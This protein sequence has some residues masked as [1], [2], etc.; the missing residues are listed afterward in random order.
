MS[1]MLISAS[2]I[3]LAATCARWVAVLALLVS[4]PVT[5]CRGETATQGQSN[6]Y[7]RIVQLISNEDWKAA[8]DAAVSYLAKVG[9]SGDEGLQARLRYIIIYTTAGA[10]STGAFEFDVLDQRVK[11]F[12]SKS[13]TLPYRPVV[14]GACEGGMNAICI[15]DPHATSFMVV[16]A[17]KTSTTI[18][19][20]EYVTLQ[21]AVDFAARG[22][23]WASITGTLRKIEPNPNK[24]R[25]I[26]MRIYIDDATVAFSKHS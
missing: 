4:V 21:Q 3:Q 20:F 11:G 22:A 24:S 5:L 18:H 25:A 10:V 7:D 1:S 16:A 12:V 19:A 9:T 13:V 14:N 26:V 6:E 15:S 23:E 8:S 2:V 17:N